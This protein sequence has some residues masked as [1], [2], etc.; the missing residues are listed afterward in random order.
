LISSIAGATGRVV[1]VSVALVA[2]VLGIQV[3][4]FHGML[5]RVTWAQSILSAGT[6]GGTVVWAAAE[7][8]LQRWTNSL[9][10][11]LI[12]RAYRLDLQAAT[13]PTVFA[14]LEKAEIELI[15][16]S[17]TLPT[18]WQALAELR[19]AGGDTAGGL[20]A[21]RMSRLTGGH[22]GYLMVERAT[23]GLKHWSDLGADDRQQ[24][25]REIAATADANGP[26]SLY[27]DIF[28]AADPALREAV[29]IEMQAIGM[30]ATDLARLGL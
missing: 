7:K 22:E 11:M 4:R 16:A 26:V 12:A 1:I 5:D 3:L 19:L 27:R 21:W 15:A 9:G 30:S 17:P 10:F 20:A 2:M 24:V 18:S 14:D 6:S 23:L 8:D 13:A 28:A 25:A 29:R